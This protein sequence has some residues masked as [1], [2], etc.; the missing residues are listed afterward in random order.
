MTLLTGQ[1]VLS[2]V[3]N[4]CRYF[5]ITSLRMYCDASC[6][7]VRSF[8]NI[9][10]L[11]RSRPSA[12][13]LAGGHWFTGQCASVIVVRTTMAGRLTEVAL[14]EEHFFKLF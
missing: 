8:V 10:A 11:A 1:L 9:R 6:C 12:R 13:A 14:Y 7:L 2:V 3:N 5:V 4:R